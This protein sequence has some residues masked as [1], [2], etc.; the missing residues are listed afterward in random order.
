MDP[1]ILGDREMAQGTHL[2]SQEASFSTTRQLL[3]ML[4]YFSTV[5][6]LCSVWNKNTRVRQTLKA[7]AQPHLL[8][9]F[10]LDRDCASSSFTGKCG[11]YWQKFCI[12]LVKHKL[13]LIND[14]KDFTV[15][16]EWAVTMS[17]QGK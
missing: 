10:K 3:E 5:R 15:G 11:N 6:K 1:W 7:Q 13:K 9:H 4:E 14:A 12:L 16:R 8:W 2:V 17:M